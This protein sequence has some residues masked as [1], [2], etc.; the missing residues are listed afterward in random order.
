MAYHPQS[1]G[2]F[3]R[4]IQTL[5]DMLRA[6]VLDLGGNWESYLPLVEFAYINSF[7]TTIGLAPIVEAIDKIRTRIKVTQDRQ[8]SYAGT[9][10]KDLEFEVEEKVFLKVAPIKGVLRKYMHDLD[11]G[12]NYQSLQVQKALSYK[13]LLIKILDQKVHKLWDK[14]I[15]LVKVQ[16]NNHGI[17]EAN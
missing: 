6:C 9:R 4:T 5:K 13:E 14:E 2:Q 10:R 7:Q 1:N 11:R 16:L 17:E 12:V 3:E 15:P 8:N